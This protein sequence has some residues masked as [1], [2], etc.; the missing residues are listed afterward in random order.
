MRLVK[1]VKY[2]VALPAFVVAT[3]ATQLVA[4]VPTHAESGTDVWTGAGDGTHFSDGANWSTSTAPVTGDTLSF[5]APGSDTTKTFVNDLTGVQF[6][7]FSYGTVG[8][9]HYSSYTFDKLAFQNNAII[10]RVGPGVDIAVSDSITAQS[11]TLSGNVN[12]SAV[13]HDINVSVANISIVNNPA[14]CAGSGSDFSV[15]W[16]PTGAATIGSG[17]AWTL[18]GTPT[19]VDVQT[20]GQLGLWSASG[21]VAYSGDITFEGGGATQGD[22]CG[23]PMSLV[24]SGDVTLSGAINFT[25][26]DI[27]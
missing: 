24:A 13:S 23:T 17:S 26:V 27:V 5:P 15:Y 2:V 1:R 6:A 10:N 20:G 12:W 3:L 7:G 19:S 8:S 25:H 11:L 16:L 18:A 4:I 21:P 14:M 9:T 22:S